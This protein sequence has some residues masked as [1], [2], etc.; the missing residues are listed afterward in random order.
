MATMRNNHVFKGHKTLLGAKYVTYGELELPLRYDIFS[1]SKNGF[2]WGHSGSAAQQLSFS[3]LYQLG[4][5]EFA[6]ENA[7]LFTTDIVSKFNSRDWLISA[8]EVLKW[9]EKHTKED[10]TGKKQEEEEKKEAPVNT[11]IVK[12]QKTIKK[13]KQK[14]NVVKEICNEL[15]I[16][17]K[18]LANILEIPEGT[19]SSWAVKNEIP[20]LGKKAIEFY[21]Q[22]KKNEQIVKSY[23]SFVKL[24]DV[25]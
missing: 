24:L 5:E 19:V 8:S 15:Q 14:S 25:S 22:S 1:L 9:I 18:E 20:R 12:T 6:R 23:K 7:S 16:T 10:D 3:I 4:N 13:P 17:Q 11:T 21:I 2:D